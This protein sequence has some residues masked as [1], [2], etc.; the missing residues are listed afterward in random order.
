M[1]LNNT[2]V[3]TLRIDGENLSPTT[4]PMERLAEYMAIFAKLIGADNQPVF[5]E[6]SKGSTCLDITV[7]ALWET[8]TEQSLLRAANDPSYKNHKYINQ[9]EEDLLKDGYKS[10]EL[11]NA[12]KQ[13]IFLVTPQAAKIT[14]SVN[15]AAKLEGEIVGVFGRNDK[16]HITVRDYGGRIFKLLA[17]VPTGQK[18]ARHLRGGFLRLQTKGVWNRTNNGWVT[19]PNKCH[20]INFDELEDIDALTIFQEMRNIPGNNWTTMNNPE[21]VCRELRD[22]DTPSKA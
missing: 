22:S 18:L 14:H 11:L 20:V 8:R 1:K 2:S 7:P 15:H 4:F 17:D 9:L 10:A 13:L 3:F 6:V 21:Q 12:R 5:K 16:M 19:D